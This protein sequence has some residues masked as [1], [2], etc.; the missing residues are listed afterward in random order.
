MIRKI[1]KQIPL[2]FLIIAF[3]AQNAVVNAA[4]KQSYN[5][6]NLQ[7]LVVSTALS[8]YYNNEYSDYEQYSMDSKITNENGQNI[9]YNS[10]FNW[11]NVTNSP[12]SINRTN[13][14][15]IDCSSFTFMTYLHALG[16]DMSEYLEY[17]PNSYYYK[18]LEKVN[19][20]SSETTYK[21]GYLYYGKGWSTAQIAKI[22]ANNFTQKN[23]I[24]SN[25]T[26]DHIAY[27]NTN[28]NNTISPIYYYKVDLDKENNY[29][30][31]E[32]EEDIKRIR[33]EIEKILEPGD[34]LV[35]R[36][37]VKSTNSYTGH[38]ILYIGDALN[39][40]EQGFLH[41]TGNDYDFTSIPVNLG[42]DDYSVRYDT[43]ADKFKKN[44]FV[45]A[46]NTDKNKDYSK[47]NNV[48]TYSISIVRPIN[49][50]CNDNSCS[51][52]VADNI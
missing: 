46:Y 5:R 2:F 12:E 25:A 27:K 33:V 31:S 30:Y 50:Y 49:T 43:W 45:G 1:R 32:S 4:E 16:Y 52:T 38:A 3:F 40:G 22:A 35:Y 17:F 19:V 41:S 37:Y 13:Q 39:N 18:N 26:A 48:V 24:D 29:Q 47:T 6:Q 9:L 14:Y 23:D 11:R 15:N 36:R 51:A 8:Y 28:S 34:I 10:S 20:K 42:E 21:N 7:D 44:I